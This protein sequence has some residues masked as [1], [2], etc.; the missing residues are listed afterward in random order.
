MRLKNLLAAI[1]IAL[2][3]VV[4][5]YSGI[6]F[7]TPERHMDL[8]GLHVAT[9]KTHFIPPLTGAIALASGLVLLFVGPRRG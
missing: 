3:V 2:G 9:T 6:T 4:L 7:E 1:L 8:F 5:A